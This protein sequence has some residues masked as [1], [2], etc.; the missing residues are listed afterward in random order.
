MRT[1]AFN[2]AW[3][4][5]DRYCHVCEAI[6]VVH[7]PF[8]RLIMGALRTLEGGYLPTRQESQDMLRKL[9]PMVRAMR[10][11]RVNA[12]GSESVN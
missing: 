3:A 11:C 1:K 10:D 7:P 2:A 12:W 4:A 5:L 8:E 6:G 9:W